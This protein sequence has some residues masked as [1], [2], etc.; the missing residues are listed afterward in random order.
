MRKESLSDKCNNM[1]PGQA[2]RIS[3]DFQ[4]Q[5]IGINFGAFKVVEYQN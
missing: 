1:K 2:M 4:K 5:L 3:R